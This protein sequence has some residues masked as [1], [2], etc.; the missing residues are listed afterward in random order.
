MKSKCKIRLELLTLS[1]L[2]AIIVNNIVIAK[3]LMNFDETDIYI[4]IYIYC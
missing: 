2:N 4:Y 3:T 1:R